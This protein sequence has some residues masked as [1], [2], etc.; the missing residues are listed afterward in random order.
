MKELKISKGSSEVVNLRKTD[1][2]MAKSLKIPKGS[3]EVVNLRGT[4]NTMA[5]FEDTK[6]R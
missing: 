3:S 1:N 5:K 4:D 2:T 6:G